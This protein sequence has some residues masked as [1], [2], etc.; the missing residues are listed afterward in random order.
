M[1]I[2]LFGLISLFF[3]S[4]WNVLI[5]ILILF[6]LFIIIRGSEFFVYKSNSFME[7]DLLSNSLLILSFWIIILC[8]LGSIKIFNIKLN[9][10]LFSILLTRLLISLFIRFTVNNYLS[11]YFMFECSLIPVLFLILGW[12]YQPERVQAGFYLIFYTLTSS[13]PLLVLILSL[14]KTS[15]LRILFISD[16][17]VLKGFVNLFLIGAFLVKFPM[18]IVHLWLPKA[19]V[20]APVSGS[21]ILAG[22]L[23]KLG[24][25]GIIRFMGLSFIFPLVLQRV[26]INFRI[27]GGLLVRLNCLNQID[28]KSL[29]AYSSIVHIRTCICVLLITGDW[30]LKGAIIIIIAHGLCSSGLFFLVNL[31]YE[32]TGRRRILI[33]K[34][35]LNLIP[36]I[37]L[38]WFLLLR[39]NISAPPTIN[40]LREINIIISLLRWSFFLFLPIILLIFFRASY[41]LYLFSLSQHGKFMVSK[42]VFSRGSVID[43][44]ILFSHWGPLNLFIL[45]IFIII[46]FFSL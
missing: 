35:L 42:Q 1:L 44:F 22:V 23:L 38:W 13:L 19:H 6:L 20:E 15:G 34:G 36:S 2:Y 25:Y 17:G 27:W 43:F 8:F 26:L 40:L 37:S 12:G 29:I 18:Y 39:A 28:I 11:F 7:L 30:G 5:F 21:I 24:G 4:N 32:R 45:C 31:V 9:Q 33:N 41:S 14:N 46:C 10:Y 3:Y 16:K